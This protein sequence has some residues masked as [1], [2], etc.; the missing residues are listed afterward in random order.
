V[1]RHTYLKI[2][3][4]ATLIIIDSKPAKP[5]PT[6]KTATENKLL[7]TTGLTVHQK[8]RFFTVVFKNKN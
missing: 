6:H 4:P 8:D 3:Q 1:Q 2:L 5:D 7:F